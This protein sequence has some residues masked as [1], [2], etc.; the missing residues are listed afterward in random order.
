[1]WVY[2]NRGWGFSAERLVKRKD[3]DWEK[4]A[5]EKTGFCNFVYMHDVPFRDA[6][7][8]QLNQYRKV[9]SAGRHLNSMNGWTVPM[10]PNRATGKVEFFRRY[11][12]TL[13]IENTIWPG[14]TTEKLVDPMFA[15][16]IPIYIGDPLAAHSFD[17][18]SYIDFGCFRN[19]KEMFEFV[20]EVDNNRDL[21]L[22]MLAAPFYRNNEIPAHARE[23][24][25]LAFFDRIATAALSRR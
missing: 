23:D 21:Y 14:Y 13:A 9:D 16:S 17:P 8:R 1:L 20:R 18:K 12:F 15:A 25:I 22:K 24:T 2:E 10:S 5:A 6:I 3:T 11:K 19:M 4:I 7:F